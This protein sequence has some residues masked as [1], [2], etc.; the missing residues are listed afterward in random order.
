MASKDESNIS[1]SYHDD[2][3]IVMKWEPFDVLRMTYDEFEEIA[4]SIRQSG[5]GK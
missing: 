2:C 4:Y 5:F 1:I 3:V